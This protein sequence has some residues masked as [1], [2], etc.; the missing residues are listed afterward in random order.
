M[1]D[2]QSVELANVAKK[3]TYFHGY[4]VVFL[5][6]K[7]THAANNTTLAAAHGRGASNNS[8]Q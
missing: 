4:V 8:S 2:A 1:K 7:A 5:L 6:S 3:Y